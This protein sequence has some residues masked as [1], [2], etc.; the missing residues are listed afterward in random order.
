[1]VLGDEALHQSTPRVDAANAL[2]NALK[3][4]HFEYTHGLWIEPAIQSFFA[5][6]HHIF[7]QVIGWSQITPIF[8]ALYGEGHVFITLAFAVWVFIYRRGLFNFIRNIFL[9]TNLFAILLYDKFPLAP[10]RLA[11]GLRWDGKP[12]HFLDAVFGGNSALKVGFDQYAAMPS[13]HVA[14][15]LIVGLSIACIARPLPVRLLGLAYPVVMLTTVIVTGNHYLLDGIGAFFVVLLATVLAFLFTWRR[16]R[17]ESFIETFRRLQRL[18][19][20]TAGR[21]RTPAKS[22]QPQYQQAQIPA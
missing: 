6:T 3:V 19:Q 13:V 11:T 5:R 7:G 4:E 1:M 14:W 2:A 17:T 16:A 10:P 21:M 18:R 15:A 12:Y 8:D 9:I 20:P 22:V